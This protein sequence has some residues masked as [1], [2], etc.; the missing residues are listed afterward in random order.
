MKTISLQIDAGKLVEAF[1]RAPDKVRNMIR[2]QLKLAVRDIKEYASDHHNYTSRSGILEREG[3][4]TKVEGN[5]GTVMLNPSVPYAQYVHEGTRRHKIRIRHK[6]SLRWPAGDGVRFA[7]SVNHPG[8]APDQF[9]YE[10]A[11]A[12]EKHVQEVLSKSVEEALRKAGL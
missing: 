9:L 2:L 12:Q 8:T 11:A 3:I 5:V 7:K 10:A 4:V 6:R 1:E